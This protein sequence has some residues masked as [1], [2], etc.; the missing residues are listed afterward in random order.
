MIK[1]YN[2]KGFIF[3]SQKGNEASIFFKNSCIFLS[4]SI[5]AFFFSNCQFNPNAPFNT[6]KCDD[7]NVTGSNT[8]KCWDE[9]LMKRMMVIIPAF[10]A[11]GNNSTNAFFLRNVPSEIAEGSSHSIS[12][13][14]SIKSFNPQAV[15]I[16]TSSPIFEINDAPS[17][18]L[19]FS[20][21]NASIEQSFSVKSLID[22]NQG[23]E[24]GAIILNYGNE[25]ATLNITN[26]DVPGNWLSISSTN[27]IEGTKGTVTAKLTKKPYENILVSFTSS[28]EALTIDNP[29]LTFTPENWSTEQTLNLTGSIDANTTN[30]T[31]TITGS[32]LG[33]IGRGTVQYLENGIAI[34]P[35]TITLVETQ[36]SRVNVFLTRQPLNNVIVTLSANHSSISFNPPT[37]TFTSSN[38]NTI[39]SSIISSSAFTPDTAI[40]N[41]APDPLV[42]TASASGMDNSSTNFRFQPIKEV[43]TWGTFTDNLNGT[44]N[45]SGASGNFGGQT[46]TTQTLTFMKCLQGQTYDILNHICKEEPTL[47]Q[48]CSTA[49]NACDNGT[50]ATSG[51]AFNSCDSLVFAGKTDWRLPSKNELKTLIHCSDKVMPNDSSSCIDN[52]IQTTLSKLF[53]TNSLYLGYDSYWS[54]SV[55]NTTNSSY[56]NYFVGGGNGGNVFSIN[57]AY[58]LTIRCL[59]TGQ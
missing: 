46:Y 54:A 57:K 32:A 42:V 44:V 21:Y 55:Q 58:A 4:F 26:K 10:Q 22:G 37:L 52:S 3:I 53:Y 45:F 41:A 34:T 2:S 43:Y 14:L 27:L 51:P 48:F 35:E 5:L 59:Y 28:Y 17:T 36:S 49:N 15:T 11:L 50:V 20:N 16:S 9:W 13:S 1:D 39:Q 12:I 40:I 6:V 33:L 23:N 19:N 47:I 24:V 29:Q 25:S 7:G 30:D 18:T 8:Q 31:V 56:V 38:W